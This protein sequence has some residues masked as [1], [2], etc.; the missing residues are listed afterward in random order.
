MFPSLGT[1]KCP[2]CD[3]QKP[4]LGIGT[5]G[6]DAG[7]GECLTADGFI[8]TSDH[9]LSAAKTCDK[10]TTYEIN[11]IR[12]ELKGHQQSSKPAT[13][14]PAVLMLKRPVGR[15]PKSAVP[16][17]R[18]ILLTAPTLTNQHLPPKIYPSKASPNSRHL[19]ARNMVQKTLIPWTVKT[20]LLTSPVN[21]TRRL[22]K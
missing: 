18:P 12:N 16:S 6:G 22:S 2:I 1:W 8:P 19:E 20:S 11:F 15:P 14:S 10:L 3:P 4:K 13:V 9:R 21:S 7:L 17:P 5:F